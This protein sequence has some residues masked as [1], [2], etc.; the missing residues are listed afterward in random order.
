MRTKNKAVSVL[1]AITAMATKQSILAFDKIP[2]DDWPDDE[3]ADV[4][5]M[6][7]YVPSQWCGANCPT[8]YRISDCWQCYKAQGKVCMD[9]DHGSM[10][11]WIQTSNV[12]AVFCC[13][14]DY[15]EGFCKD[16]NLMKDGSHEMTMA[17]SPPSYADDPATNG[18]KYADVFTGKRNNQMFAYC[19]TISQ[20]KCGVQGGSSKG[21]AMDLKA[22]PEI[23]SVTATGLNYLKQ[24][25]HPD[26]GNKIISSKDAE[27]DAC[28][29]EVNM[30]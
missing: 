15:N 23:G 25:I 14:Q 24:G 9:R 21:G 19:P 17:C 10:M 1:L 13:K 6:A 16:G 20:A 5:T 22:T 27:Y 30:D 3:N 29:Y 18:G 2:S 11:H 4:P 28:Y 26:M 12:G 8:D 7:D